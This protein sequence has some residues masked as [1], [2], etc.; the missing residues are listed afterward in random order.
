MAFPSTLQDLQRSVLDKLRLESPQAASWVA[1]WL[2]RAYYEVCSETECLQQAATMALTS[3]DA[4][5]TLPA[6]VVR[7]KQIVIQPY[8]QTAYWPPLIETTLDDILR[9][10][11]YGGAS[12]IVSGSSTHYAVAGR[13]QLELW[14]TPAAADTLQMYYS[15]FPA[16]LASGTDTPVIEE[17]YATRLLEYG[18]LMEGAAFSGDEQTAELYR[19]VFDRYMGE[20][21]RHLNRRKGGHTGQIAVT[22]QRPPLPRDRSIDIRTY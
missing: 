11:G 18:A 2:N 13:N 22:G 3:G 12:Y 10:R 5:Y 16:A 6:A 17:P 7:I 19:A 14:P 15:Y 8:G 20:F 1:D 4:S 9:K 21:R